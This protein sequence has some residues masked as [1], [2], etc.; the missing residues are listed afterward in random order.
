[1][2]GLKFGSD[3]DSHFPLFNTD[4]AD[5]GK[6]GAVDITGEEADE[7][8]ISMKKQNKTNL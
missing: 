7:E 5:L 4:F 6:L 3:K 8:C 2:D 1:M